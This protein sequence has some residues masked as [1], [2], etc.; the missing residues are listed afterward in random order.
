MKKFFKKENYLYIIFCIIVITILLLSVFSQT[1]CIFFLLSILA[2]IF[3]II[4]YK[5]TLK[6]I[7]IKFTKTE[8][9]I[10]IIS[11][12]LIYLFYIISVLNRNFIYYWDYSCYYNIQTAAAEKFSISLLDGIKYFIGSTW[13]GEYGSFLTF[14][15]E[16]IYKFTNHTVNSYL[17]SSI[18]I[19][20]PYIIIAL[21]ILIKKVFLFFKIEKDNLIF[22][23]FL[24]I[25]LLFPI[26]HATAI[27]GQPDF[28]GLAFIFLIISLTIDYDFKELE[29][30]RLILIFLVTFMLIISRRWYLY[31]I[32]SYYLCYIIKILIT[33]KKESLGGI[34]KN[35]LIYGLIV[36]SI[37]LITLFPLIKN[38]IFG[39]ISNYSEYYKSGGFI[40]E[41][42]NQINYLGY[43]TLGIC[44]LGIGYGLSKKEYRLIT[45]LSIIECFLIIY[46]FNMIQSMGLHHSLMLVPTYLYWLYLSIMLLLQINDISKNR[47]CLAIIA[48]LIINFSYAICNNSTDNF[49]SKIPLTVPYQED[50][51]NLGEVASWLKENLSNENNAY[52]ITHNNKYNPDK[53]RNYYLPDQSI[54]NY[55]PYGSAIIGVHK[56]PTELFSAKYIII[57]EPFESVSIEEKYYEVF[58]K[59]LDQ[60]K[61]EIEET[62]DMGNGYK[63][64]IYKRVKKTDDEEKKIYLNA[65]KEESE[66]YPALYKDIIET[67]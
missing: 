59:L 8:K 2:N 62:F 26:F 55:L 60:G 56:F 42:K 48:C 24:L 18:T 50:Y 14:F 66:K 44:L 11:I 41:I 13:S 63:L 35:L 57:T 32:I 40:Y 46:L 39:S 61:F 31:W 1:K 67:Y 9:I 51:K 16:I 65:L 64:L 34:I 15:P 19:Y 7:K 30:N 53:L 17:L 21:S 45:I 23:M 3:L 22:T 29:L 12:I 47:I 20:I 58:Q 37:L 49:F 33:N 43:L 27:Y 6:K 28:F 52:M 36:L 54:A 38:I 5:E 10:I 4:I 25:F